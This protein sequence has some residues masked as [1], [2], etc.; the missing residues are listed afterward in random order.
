MLLDAVYV[1]RTLINDPDIIL[2]DEPFSALDS[3]TR[4]YLDGVL[5]EAVETFHKTVVLVTYDIHEAV[6][7]PKRV[8]VL[9]GRP[10]QVK[11]IC[12]IDIKARSPIGARSDP[13]LSGYFQALCGELDIQRSWVQHDAIRF[14]RTTQ[15]ESACPQTP[16]LRDRPDRSW[17]RFSFTQNRLRTGGSGRDFRSRGY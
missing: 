15:A 6:A 9:G 11:K 12:D 8:V 5:M 4:L 16:P 1:I 10:S 7:L 17:G 3:E 14:H 2:L 13:S